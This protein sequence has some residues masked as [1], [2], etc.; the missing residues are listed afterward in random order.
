MTKSAYRPKTDDEI[1]ELAKRVY[2]NEVF[3][4]W[5]MSR[6]EDLSM[7]FMVLVFIDE[8]ARNWLLENDIQFFYEAYDQA[9]PRG[10]NGQPCFT[11]AHY[12]SRD[13]GL[14]L[15]AKV[16]EIINLVG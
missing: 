1:T 3:V 2:R 16:Q 6:P 11:S 5:M 10:V 12:L 9:L 4:S 15:H 8:A 14:R 13:D 7:V